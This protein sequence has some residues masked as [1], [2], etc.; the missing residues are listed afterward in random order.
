[1]SCEDCASEDR[2]AAT[3]GLSLLEW[4]A[5][6]GVLVATSQ[7]VTA[8]GT[9]SGEGRGP[10]GLYGERAA[11]TLRGTCSRVVILYQIPTSWLASNNGVLRLYASSEGNRACVQEWALRA[12]D[13]RVNDGAAT[14]VYGVLQVEGVPSEQWELNVAIGGADVTGSA[15]FTMLGFGSATGAA[16]SGERAGA[17]TTDMAYPVHEALNLGFNAT[18]GRWHPLL[19]DASGNLLVTGAGA[20]GTV[21]VTGATTPDTSGH[22]ASPSNTVPVWSFGM[23]FDTVSGRWAPLPLLFGATTVMAK[24]TAYAVATGTGADIRL[25]ANQQGVQGVVLGITDPTDVSWAPTNAR[26]AALATTSV[27]ATAADLYKFRGNN[28]SATG[29][30]LCVVNKASAPANADAILWAAWV[31]ATNGSVEE[32]F[33]R[34]L[35]CSVGLAMCWS[36]TS[37]TVTLVAVATSLDLQAQ[38]T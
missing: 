16:R 30:F 5:E 38:Y 31:P 2:G 34:P 4:A 7:K 32:R 10:S 26:A 28:T 3:D 13:G 23:G 1:M 29:A 19:V 8:L 37:T 20:G 9:G 22:T 36:T 25:S 27:K 33:E 14:P 21:L 17:S 6:N 15:T 18:D 35:R 24:T 12:L 11:C